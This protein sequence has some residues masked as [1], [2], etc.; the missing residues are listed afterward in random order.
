MSRGHA[1]AAPCLQAAIGNSALLFE[2]RLYPASMRRLCVILGAWAL[3]GAGVVQPAAAG[4]L[5]GLG[6]AQIAARF[7]PRLVLHPAERY[8]PTSADELLALG[9]TLV[10]RDGSLLR[11]APLSAAALPIGSS[12]AGGLPC[13]YALRLDCG[14]VASRPCP[15]PTD[16]RPTPP[17]VP[18][19]HLGRCPRPRS[20]SVPGRVC[21]PANGSGATRRQRRRRAEVTTPAPQPA[22]TGRRPGP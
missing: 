19:R 18:P 9:A 10:G 21:R 15:A 17:S 4:T 7:A 13:A 5:N 22:I 12:C 2:R 16:A 3:L 6:D 14:L 8:A 1:L 11:P 20:G